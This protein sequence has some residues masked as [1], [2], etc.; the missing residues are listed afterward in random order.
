MALTH[1]VDEITAISSQGKQ[2]FTVERGGVAVDGLNDG[3]DEGRGDK[4]DPFVVDEC[5]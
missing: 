3:H 5:E 4:T 1:V 2:L